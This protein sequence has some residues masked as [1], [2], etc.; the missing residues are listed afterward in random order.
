MSLICASGM[1]QHVM[2]ILQFYWVDFYSFSLFVNPHQHYSDTFIGQQFKYDALPLKNWPALH[3]DA[4]K[5]NKKSLEDVF[6]VKCMQIV[7]LPITNPIF[8]SPC[9]DSHNRWL[10]L[11]CLS[12]VSLHYSAPCQRGDC[13]ISKTGSDKTPRKGN[14]PLKMFMHYA[15]LSGVASIF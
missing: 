8:D 14:I 6:H 11:N 12:F 3:V 5:Y 7:I 10:P 15:F 9:S 4:F 2:S 1:P 13:P